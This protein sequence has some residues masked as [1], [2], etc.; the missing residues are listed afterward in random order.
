MDRVRLIWTKMWGHVRDHINEV[1]VKEKKVAMFAVDS[2]KQLSIK[3][4]QKD[5]LYNFQF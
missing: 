1:A 3:F 2:L 4:L 5:E